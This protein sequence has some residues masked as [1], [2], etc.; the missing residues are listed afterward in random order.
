PPDVNIFGGDTLLLDRDA[1]DLV[2]DAYGD[3]AAAQAPYAIEQD[4]ASAIRLFA[5]E[6][7]YDAAKG[8]PYFEE[9]LGHS[10][11]LSVLKSLIE[12]AALSVPKVATARAY[13]TLTRDRIVYGQVQI[14]TTAGQQL[15]VTEVFMGNAPAA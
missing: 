6:L 8:I 15:T 7:W 2:V 4:V 11:P 12:Q 14:T 13:V 5:G 9:V 3:I 1:W 10:P